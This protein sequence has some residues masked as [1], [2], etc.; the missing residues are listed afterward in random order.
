M[1][2]CWQRIEAPTLWIAAGDRFERMDREGEG[3]FEWR[4]AHCAMASGRWLKAPGTMFIMIARGT[5]ANSRGFFRAVAL[6][7]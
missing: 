6:G 4:F 5:R 7:S 1:G 2:S 3:G